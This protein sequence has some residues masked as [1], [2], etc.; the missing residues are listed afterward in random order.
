M[1]LCTGV[2]GIKS[3]AARLWVI[4]SNSVH[5][6]GWYQVARR[7][8]AAGTEWLGARPRLAPSGSPLMD[9]CMAFLDIRTEFMDKSN[10]ISVWHFWG[11]GAE[12]IDESH[13]V[14]LW[15]FGMSEQ[16][17][18]NESHWMFVWSFAVSHIRIQ[19]HV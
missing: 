5:G 17:F 13:W 14:S 9:F 7:N 8:G 11:I 15:L 3:F 12:F 1:V 18:I 2:V 16:Q 10:W 4:P 6:R 19:Q